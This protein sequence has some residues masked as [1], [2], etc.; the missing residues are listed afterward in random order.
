MLRTRFTATRCR[1][2]TNNLGIVLHPPPYPGL[3]AHG[4][5]HP[6]F[7]LATPVCAFTFI[8]LYFNNKTLESHATAPSMKRWSSCVIIRLQDCCRRHTVPGHG[9]P[10]IYLSS[11]PTSRAAYVFPT[12]GYRVVSPEDL[13]QEERLPAR[14]RDGLY[15]LALPRPRVG[16]NENK[17]RVLTDKSRFL[18]KDRLLALKVGIVM[19]ATDELDNEVVISRHL[20]SLEGDHPGRQLCRVVLDDFQVTGPCGLHQCL[21]FDALGMTMWKFQ[22]LMPGKTINMTLLQQT[23]QLNLLALDFLHQANVVHTDISPSNILLGVNDPSRISAIEQAERDEPCA[24]K[25]LPDRTIYLS[26]DVPITSGSPVIVDFGCARIRESHSGDV[27][28]GVYRAPEIILGMDWDFK[29]DI[30]SIGVMIW[31]LFEGGNLFHAVKDGLLDDEKHLAEM[32]SLMGPPPKKFLEGSS[33]CQRYWDMDANHATQGNWIASTPIP[34]QSFETREHQL[35]GT[36]RELLLALARK[37]LRWLPEDRPSA[38]DLIGNEFLT[39]HMPK[40]EAI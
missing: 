28:P 34:D 8:I 33:Q 38:V 15:S 10:E 4:G 24:R 6:A 19:K 40:D 35:T 3:F 23:L 12:E 16:S 17:S 7:R 1:G 25:I 26:R 36:D 11:P 18:R 27:M 32:V 37:I 9:S 21:L 29:I 20:N 5:A 30:W 2:A 14:L 39:Q 31:N 22:N 13:I